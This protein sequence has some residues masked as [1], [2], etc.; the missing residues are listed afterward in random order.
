[1]VGDVGAPDGDDSDV[2]IAP[3]NPEGSSHEDAALPRAPWSRRPQ[4]TEPDNTD[5]I[6]DPEQGND[7]VAKDDNTGQDPATESPVTQPQMPEAPAASALPKRIP[8]GEPPTEQFAAIPAEE[9]PAPPSEEPATEQFP[10]VSAGYEPPAA[11]EPVA[12]EPVVPEPV[13]SEPVA[14]EPA[15]PEPP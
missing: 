4:Q 12:P 14:S 8:D 13:A 2:M 5:N 7:A 3:G 6:V 1:M 15:P 11:P 10:A 9:K